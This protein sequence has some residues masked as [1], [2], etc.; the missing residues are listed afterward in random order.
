MDV[1][2]VNVL[3]YAVNPDADHHQRSRRWL[4]AAL[5]HPGSVGLTWA[6]LIGFVRL[7]T[8]PGVWPEPLDAGDALDIVETFLVAPGATILEPT[9]RH[10]SVVRGLLAETGT[11]G[12]LTNDAHLA[13]IAIEHGAA[14][15][16]F[17]TDFGRF[18]GVRW[19]PPD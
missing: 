14:V 13:A 8:H 6:V 1:V 11:A 10:L 16:T 12:N 7:A 4:E 17:D 19:H 3:L 18:P 9:G 2:D 15:C 5:R